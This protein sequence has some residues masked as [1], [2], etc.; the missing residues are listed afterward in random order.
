MIDAPEEEKA[1]NLA[2]ES[3]RDTCYWSKDT[4]TSGDD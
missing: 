3:Y 4:Q 1:Y 2:E